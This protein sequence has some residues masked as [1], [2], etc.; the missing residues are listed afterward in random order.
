LEQATYWEQ[1]VKGTTAKP[2]GVKA[3]GLHWAWVVG[4]WRR[5]IVVREERV[6][7]VAGGR[8]RRRL[9]GIWSFLGVV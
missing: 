6:R 5:R 7:L 3:Q 4:V 2:S 1:P 8:V 9:G